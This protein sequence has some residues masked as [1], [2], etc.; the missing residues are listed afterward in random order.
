MTN[1][2]IQQLKAKLPRKWTA[3]ISKM[4]GVT[5]K[6]VWRVFNGLSSNTDV[7]D[8]GILLIQQEQQR[9]DAVKQIIES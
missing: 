9:S 6:T 5:P 1:S 7:I 2:E 4:T 8:A 3:L